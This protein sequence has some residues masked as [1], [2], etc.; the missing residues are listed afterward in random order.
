MAASDEAPS[1]TRAEKEDAKRDP[2][3]K[4]EQKKKAVSFGE[5]DVTR[6]YSPTPYAFS[7]E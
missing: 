4:K 6:T 5:R 7:P 2:K 3:P 1:E